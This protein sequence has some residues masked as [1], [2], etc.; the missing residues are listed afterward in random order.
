MH[1]GL[2]CFRGWVG[3]GGGVVLGRA[4]GLF[5][6]CDYVISH[7]R[8]CLNKGARSALTLILGRFSLSCIPFSVVDSKTVYLTRN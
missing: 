4:G 5:V 8:D 6:S 1:G 3:V 2:A 7:V